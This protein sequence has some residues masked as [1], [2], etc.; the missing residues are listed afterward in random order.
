MEKAVKDFVKLSK[1]L[2]LKLS[3][4]G[5]IIAKLPYAA[6]MI[7]QELKNIGV[8]YNVAESTRD[9]GVD[10]S[11]SKKPAIRKN[12]LK[13]RIKKSR[14]TLTIIYK[15]AQIRR[16]AHVLF[17]GAGF[18]KSTLGTSDILTLIYRVVPNRSSC[19]KCSWFQSR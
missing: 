13:N 18:S 8:V 6:K 10:F 14:G 17:S 1:K 9:L 11:F 5:V 15:I 4:K 2:G 16:R 3:T 7:V 12:I 19:S